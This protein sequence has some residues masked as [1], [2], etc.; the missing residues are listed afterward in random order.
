MSSSSSSNQRSRPTTASSPGFVDC[1][2]VI[3]RWRFRGKMERKE[4]VPG[5][6]NR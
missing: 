3:I 1:N 2:G 5:I 6:G 4:G